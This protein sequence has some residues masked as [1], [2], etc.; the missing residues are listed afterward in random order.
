M[1]Q[2]NIVGDELSLEVI[3]ALEYS[4]SIHPGPQKHTL[5]PHYSN[6]AIRTQR[7]TVSQGHHRCTAELGTKARSFFLLSLCS[8]YPWRCRCVFENFKSLTLKKKEIY[9]IFF[10]YLIFTREVPIF[11]IFCY[12]FIDLHEYPSTSFGPGSMTLCKA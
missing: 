2:C 6:E 7:S 8:F 10:L 12:D 5:F 11:F 9:L 1:I 3:F 4:M